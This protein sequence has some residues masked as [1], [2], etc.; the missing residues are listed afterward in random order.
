MHRPFQ[1]LQELSLLDEHQ[2]SLFLPETEFVRSEEERQTWETF[3]I[4]AFIPFIEH[5]K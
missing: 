3:L 1:I 5:L 2:F 4:L